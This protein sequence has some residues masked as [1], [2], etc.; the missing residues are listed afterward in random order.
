MPQ[1]AAAG[2]RFRD[3]AQQEPLLHVGGCGVGP[4]QV[5]EACRAQPVA[6]RWGYDWA[7]PVNTPAAGTAQLRSVGTW[8]VSHC[9][10]LTAHKLPC[11]IR[12]TG[13]KS[14]VK[15]GGVLT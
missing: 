4:R 7:G 14:A 1:S 6:L 3:V 5:P 15:V 12:A 2:H 8:P 11:F 10:C 9:L 13:L